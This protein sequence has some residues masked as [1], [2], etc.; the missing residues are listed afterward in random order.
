MSEQVQNHPAHAV[1][2]WVVR[3]VRQPGPRPLF[4]R[5]EVAVPVGAKVAA[6]AVAVVAAVVVP[7]DRPG[8]GWVLALLVAAVVLLACARLSGTGE[9]KARRW[10]Q[11]GWA[12]LAIALLAVGA[13]RAAEWLFVLCGLAAA[14]AASLAVVGKRT[15]HGTTYDVLAVPLEAFRA[16]PWLLRRSPRSGRRQGRALGA[17]LLSGLV[18]V[19]FL[20]LLITSDPRF[21]EFVGGLVPEV[22]PGSA[23]Q[24]ALVFGVGFAAMAAVFLISADPLPTRENR[25]TTVGDR[26]SWTSLLGTLSVLFTAYVGV[27][28]TALFGGTD[29]VLRTDGLTSADYARGGF[30][31]LCACT[32]LTLGIV[33]AALRWAP[34][35]TRADRTVLRALL[36]ALTVLSLVVVLSALSR[37]WTYQQAYGFTVLRLL[38]EVCEIWLGVVFVLIGATLGTLRAGWLPRA[39]IATAAVAL[40]GLA[41]ANPEAAITTANLDRAAQ[42][43]PLDLHYLRQFS[44]D[45]APVVAERRPDAAC[46]LRPIARALPDD[47]WPAWNLSRSQAR[48]ILR[49]QAPCE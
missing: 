29:Y 4:E 13:L 19:V 49:A 38:V 42:G 3:I 6:L 27:Q 22:R 32:V 34:K 5:A 17:V 43:K 28:A 31:Q 7:V 2:P 45:V 44:A 23:V 46:L 9:G 33:A 41:A 10:G 25:T 18:L 40:L 37:M 47:S 39:A 48:E 16:V 21:A 1:P 30:W 26:L 14:V 8:I 36:G 12:L 24:A 35:A 20:P 15:V 11:A